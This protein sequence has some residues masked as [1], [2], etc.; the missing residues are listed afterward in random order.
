MIVI[1]QYQLLTIFYGLLIFRA[2]GHRLVQRWQS[3]EHQP[4]HTQNR[5]DSG[6]CLGVRHHR[7]DT[8]YMS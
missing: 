1:K 4:V 3:S 6:G 7:P 5:A 8:R 2:L